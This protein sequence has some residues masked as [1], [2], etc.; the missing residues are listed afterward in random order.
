MCSKYYCF[1][2]VELNN[3]SRKKE[4]ENITFPAKMGINGTR[5]QVERNVKIKLE[6][7]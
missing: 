5:V 1:H 7:S 2:I 6:G 4:R 3:I